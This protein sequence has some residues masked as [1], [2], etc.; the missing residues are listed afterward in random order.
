MNKILLKSHGTVERQPGGMRRCMKKYTTNYKD[1]IIF[2]LLGVP[3][4]GH[5]HRP[6]VLFDQ[7]AAFL[8][9]LLAPACHRHLPDPTVDSF[10]SRTHMHSLPIKNFIKYI[11]FTINV[12]VYVV[13][14]YR[15]FNVLTNYLANAS[16]SIF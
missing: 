5:Q 13:Y 3:C 6:P 9:P 15:V 1:I 8:A 7:P 14:I 4:V 16:L 10:P 2:G 11:Y 12:Y